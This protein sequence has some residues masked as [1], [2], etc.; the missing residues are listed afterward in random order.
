SLSMDD[1][2]VA[3]ATA[4]EW[5]EG[6]A[7]SGGAALR[8]A[9]KLREHIVRKN[10]MF[11]YQYRPQNRTYLLGFRSH[12]QGNNAV[13]LEQYDKFIEELEAGIAGLRSPAPVICRLTPTQRN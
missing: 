2:Q 3:S 5:S 7:L 8:Q 11:F 6:V 4:R 13:E 1:R 10:A 12:E 9:G